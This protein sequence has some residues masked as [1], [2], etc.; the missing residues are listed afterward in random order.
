MD[1]PGGTIG[2]KLCGFRPPPRFSRKL[3]ELAVA[4]KLQEKVLGG[5]KAATRRFLLDA[6]KAQR[7][8]DKS[9]PATARFKV[10][11]MLM[12]EWKGVTHQVTVLGDGF[13]F[14]DKR[15]RSL[16]EIAGQITGAHWSGPT[17]FGLTKLP[18]RSELAQIGSTSRRCAV[19]TRKS[20]E[21]GLQQDFNSLHAQREACEAYIRSQAA[22]A[23]ASS[24][25]PM[26]MVGSRAATW[27][28]RPSSSSW[29]ISAPGRSMS[30]S[31]IRWTDSPG[32]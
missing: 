6:A 24:K 29:P 3:M 22:R 14:D 5:L 20:S 28:G 26:T 15:Y 25:P 2:E 21:E 9:Q 27:S 19:Y 13:L 10:G 12:R 4:Y 1:R 23:G 11:T 17:F 7:K 32:R 8:L 16:S 18:G 30:S 31:Y